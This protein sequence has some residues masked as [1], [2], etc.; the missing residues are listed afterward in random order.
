MKKLERQDINK[1]IFKHLGNFQT[2]EDETNSANYKFSDE[3][4]EVFMDLSS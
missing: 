2:S 4:F 1:E 3:L